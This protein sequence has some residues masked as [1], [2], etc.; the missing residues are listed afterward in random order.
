MNAV[1]VGFQPGG[2]FGV[3][4]VGGLVMVVDGVDI[5]V[6]CCW[7]VSEGVSE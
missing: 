1:M 7:G 3:V 6:Y 4:V 5:V 2:C